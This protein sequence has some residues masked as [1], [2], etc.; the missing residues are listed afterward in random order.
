MSA[1]SGGGDLT[2]VAADTAIF[3]NGAIAAG[4]ID[5]N[6]PRTSVSFTGNT[7]ASSF[8]H[9]DGSYA[10]SFTGTS[11]SITADT[12]FIN[13]GTLTLGDAQGDS[14]TFTNGLAT[15]GSAT[16]PALLNVAGSVITTNTRM[17]IGAVTLTAATTFDTG[18]AA[19][20]ILNIGAV[21]GATTA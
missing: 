12:S 2:L 11:N 1:F 17:D 20:G 18:N 9:E 10:I 13:E 6:E 3:G 4:V 19:A 8:V 21:T 7:S 14:I 15:T 16:N 5:V